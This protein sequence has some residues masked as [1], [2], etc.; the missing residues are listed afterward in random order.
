MALSLAAAVDAR[1][2]A[3]HANPGPAALLLAMLIWG[4]TLVVTKSLLNGMGAATL[5]SVRFLVAFLCL[6]PF[7]Y[8]AGFRLRD[9]VRREF[10]LFGLT[11][12]VLHNG[13][14]TWGL[15]YTS[16]GSA[17]LIIG[18]IPAVTVALSRVF[19]RESLPRPRT[20]GVTL[21]VL[22]VVL[23]TGAPTERGALELLGN[24]LVFG[25]VLAWGVYTI[26]G[27]KMSVRVPAI[28]GTAAGTGAALL[29]LI[30]AAVVE[31]WGEGLPTMAAS[32]VT[33]LLY[34]GLGASAA[35]YALWNF[36]LEH[37]DASVAAPYVNLVP[38]IGLLLAV[39]LGESLGATDV[40]GGATVAA[41]VWLSTSRRFAPS[42][43]TA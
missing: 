3:V 16:P 11:G 18:G 4:G 1:R 8:R 9:V 30:P 17:A 35:A 23:V 42:P 37:V 19:L 7:A 20:V 22:G 41:G 38:I 36:A 21:S 26:Q 5:L 39:M 2:T 6:A 40:A 15:R 33:G 27:K 13:L 25:G 12:I 32:D 31:R 34:L 29:F 28:V 43:A 14:E 10:V 24:L